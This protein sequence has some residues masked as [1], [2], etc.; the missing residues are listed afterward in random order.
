VGGESGSQFLSDLNAGIAT[1]GISGIAAQ[2]GTNGKLQFTGGSLLQVQATTT[3]LV[4]GSEPV[5]SGTSLLNGGNYQT[6]AGA[7]VT[8][9]SG[10]TQ[11]L[12]ITAGGTNYVAKLDNTN[13]DTIGNTVT[14]LNI[15]L[16]N[17]DDS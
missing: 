4:S 9:G 5:T 14:A 6:A 13:G 7:W 10:E 16:P 2:I 1:A 3:G 12:T 8:F 17:T 11:A 15:A